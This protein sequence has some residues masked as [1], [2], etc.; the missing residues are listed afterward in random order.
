MTV[1]PMVVLAVLVVMR[2]AFRLASQLPVQ[3]GL[4][5]SFHCPIG[6]PGHHVDPLLSK[7]RQGSLTNAPRNDNLN[8]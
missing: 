1:R 4:D 5:Q 2:A 7:E 8:P 6:M 3:V